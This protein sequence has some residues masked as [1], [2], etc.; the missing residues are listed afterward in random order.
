M[1]IRTVEE[2]DS[3]LDS[4]IAWRQRELILIKSLVE[5]N[6]N[7]PLRLN[8]YLRSGVTML[9]AHWEGF[10]KEASVAYLNF[11]S[12]QRLRY[13]ELATNFVAFALKSKLDEASRTNKAMIHNEV[14]KFFLFELS[15]RSN[16]PQSSDAI[17]T[18]S[19][20]KS[21]VFKNI[22]HSLGLE[23]LPQYQLR[24]TLIDRRL[25]KTR[26]EVAHG[27]FIN[28]G[29]D[30]FIE[31]FDK[32]TEVIRTFRNQISNAAAMETYKRT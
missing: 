5:N 4:S 1:K 31:L 22:V 25:L 21:E 19:N 13:D 10:V 23:Y 32:I 17:D 11:V 28:V 2:L 20:L 29:F 27:E 24:E 15:Q 26:N 9:Y 7:A 8:C 18:A 6:K 12:M 30:D 14:V 16:I 3:F